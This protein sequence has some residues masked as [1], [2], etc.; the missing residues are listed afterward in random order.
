MR[1]QLCRS[2][3]QGW[4]RSDNGGGVAQTWP[5]LVV[6]KTDVRRAGET[7]RRWFV[8]ELVSETDVEAAQEVLTNWRAVHGFVRNT[9]AMGLRS[10]ATRLGVRAEIASRTKARTSIYAKLAERPDL[11]LDAL[12][13][14]AGAR[15]V[16]ATM[17]EQDELVAAYDGSNEVR[18]VLDYRDGKESGYRAVHLDLV[19]EDRHTTAPERRRR[20]VELQIRTQAQHA[21]ADLVESLGRRTGHRLKQGLGPDW[22]LQSLADL[23]ATYA[24]LD[25]VVTEGGA[26]AEITA[27]VD[28]RRAA[29]EHGLGGIS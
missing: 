23:G 3:V 9:A 8:G 18:R 10:R 22:L 25:A 7:L 27:V 28:R 29:I 26:A 1:P 13:D 20:R 21:W 15:A 24:D 4:V 6:S 11:K 19:L 17:R 16:V 12:G 2:G 14:I 5:D